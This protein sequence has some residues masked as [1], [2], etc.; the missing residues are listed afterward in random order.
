MIYLS[1]GER[2]RFPGPNKG[3]GGLSVPGEAGEKG[4]GGMQGREWGEGGRR[5]WTHRA[6][7]CVCAHTCVC[8]CVVGMWTRPWWSSPFGSAEGLGCLAYHHIHSLMSCPEWGEGDTG[9]MGP[10]TSYFPSPAADHRPPGLSRHLLGKFPSS[11]PG[12]GRIASPLPVEDFLLHPAPDLHP[13][14]GTPLDQPT[15]FSLAK[16]L[17]PVLWHLPVLFMVHVETFVGT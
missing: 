13:S 11:Q 2:V 4:K 17:P 7:D 6:K 3:W 14:P 15:N 12:V 1:L 8:V 16:G 9:R 10:Y 5:S